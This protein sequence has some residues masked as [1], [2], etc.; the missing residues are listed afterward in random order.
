QV[1]DMSEMKALLLPEPSMF[2]V[3]DTA[4][5]FQIRFPLASP[6]Y[7]RLGRN[8][9]YLSP[10]DNLTIN[11]DQK[12]A[13]LAVFKGSHS[14]ENEYLRET[15]YP[16]AGSFLEAGR[17]VQQTVDATVKAIL[18]EAA[19]RTASLQQYAGS[20]SK[21]FLRLETARIRADILNS[22]AGI[23]VYFPDVRH[24]S[25]DSTEKFQADFEH[26]ITPY[27]LPYE[28]NFLDPSLLKLVVYTDIAEGL[29]SRAAEQD[30]N[31]RQIRHWLACAQLADQLKAAG[32]RNAKLAFR[33]KIEALTDPAYRQALQQTLERELLL[34]NGDPAVDFT[35]M[36]RNH[37]P[38]TLSSLKGKLVYIDL[39]ATWCGPCLQE[40]PALQKLKEAYQD[41]PAIVFLSLSI[42]DDTAA[43]KNNLLQRN[44]DGLQWV[45]DRN[46]LQAYHIIGVPRILL[47]DRNFHVADM[48]GPLPSSKRAVMDRLQELLA[49]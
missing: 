41:N 46:S 18:A 24:L 5:N 35:A 11:A 2:F 26:T 39:W 45:I 23:Q 37:H 14:R 31:A 21:E 6:N 29:V 17:F 34:S 9:L 10:G 3:P 7:F 22:F 27:R 19:K 12:D 38:V 44:A 32:D 1:E 4:G 40:M 43:W 30:K 33:P 13:R 42:D 25:K 36:D 8:I 15:P 49:K 48:N 20:V 47:I 28:H 16:K